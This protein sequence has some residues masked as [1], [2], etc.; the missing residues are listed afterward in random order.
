MWYNRFLSQAII[1][2]DLTLYNKIR[3]NKK[4]DELLYV[5][6]TNRIEKQRC[7]KLTR[8]TV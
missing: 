6:N 7:K 8:F 3:L 5:D 4:L 2:N 1:Y